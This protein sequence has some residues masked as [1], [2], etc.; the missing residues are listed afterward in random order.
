MLAAPLQSAIA[1][2]YARWPVA[3]VYE[4]PGIVRGPTVAGWPEQLDAMRQWLRERAAWID[5]QYQ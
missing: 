5:E 1:R 3:Q 4:N 2:D